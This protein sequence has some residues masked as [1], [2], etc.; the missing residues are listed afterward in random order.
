MKRSSLNNIDKRQLKSKDGLNFY[1]VVKSVSDAVDI[2]SLLIQFEELSPGLFSA[3]A[4]SHTHKDEVFII[5]GGTGSLVVNNVKQDISE[6]DIISFE[7]EDEEIHVIHNT[8]EKV[9]SFISVATN[10]KQDIINYASNT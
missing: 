2:K 1:S 3:L 8:S 7:G 9:L 10:P 5:T 4:H 6:G